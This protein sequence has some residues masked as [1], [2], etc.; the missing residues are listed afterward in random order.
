VREL[1]QRGVAEV[2]FIGQD[3]GIWGTD[4]A[5]S[6]NLALLLDRASSEFPDTWFRVLYLQ[7]AGINDE[8]L[9]LMDSRDNICSYF[10]IPLQHTNADVLKAMNR[11]GSTREY[12][13]LVERIR[14]KVRGVQLRT[15]LMAGFPGETQEQFEELLDFVDE[16]EFDYAVVFPY[17]RKTGS[18]AAEF[19]NQVD[20]D[21]KIERAQQL[22]DACEAI[23]HKRNE[24]HIGS[25]LDV[26][27]EGF[28]ETD[29]GPEAVGRW[30]GQAPEVDGQVH[31]A[32]EEGDEIEIGSI[33]RVEITDSF[34]YDLE[35][36]LA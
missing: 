8:L 26:L 1:V 33:V 18:K 2:V 28:E 36:V 30:M 4:L 9:E 10:D 3:T 23:G 35:G 7:P 27:V 34:C 31:I 24:R 19:D 29:I 21:D 6:Q 13:D 16:A 12:L 15:T 22:L 17:S 14:A 5:G 20:E 25:V 32:L 11:K